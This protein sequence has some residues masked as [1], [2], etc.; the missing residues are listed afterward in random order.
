MEK[1]I[2]EKIRDGEEKV[3]IE[4]NM[5][6]NIYVCLFNLI[7]SNTNE[8]VPVSKIKYNSPMFGIIKKYFISEI[9]IKDLI[10]ETSKLEF[11][12]LRNYNFPIN[13]YNYSG[14]IIPYEK[15][16]NI[17]INNLD[18]YEKEK[19]LY[20]NLI[21]N[22]IIIFNRYYKIYKKY[23]HNN[24]FEPYK[25]VLIPYAY[26]NKE[27]K[28]YKII[29]ITQ[30]SRGHQ[31][32]FTIKCNKSEVIIVYK[33]TEIILEKMDENIDEFIYNM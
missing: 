13:E 33:L 2:F 6:S 5:T 26:D 3:D 16:C 22:K 15:K 11:T 24:L 20:N 31:N 9:T 18:F 17:I 21:N 28:K 10:N 1:N 19:I 4:D 12:M 30:K 8:I 23:E 14:K 32:S 27:Y 7:A 25:N 29:N